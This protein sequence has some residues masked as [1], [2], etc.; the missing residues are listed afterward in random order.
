MTWTVNQVYIN[1]RTV[2]LLPRKIAIFIIYSLLNKSCVCNEISDPKLHGIGA[3]FSIMTIMER[4]GLA[5]L[6]KCFLTSATAK[7]KRTPS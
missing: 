3:I 1:V 4:D 5:R 7:I 2:E 6:L